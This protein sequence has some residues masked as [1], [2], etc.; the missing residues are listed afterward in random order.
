MSADGSVTFEVRSDNSH[1]DSDL[2]KAEQQIKKKAGGWTSLISSNLTSKL[3][4]AVG[5][6][7]TEVWNL[8]T[9]FEDGMASV[10]T[11][12][13]TASVDMDSLGDQL[14]DLSS[15]YGLEASSLASSAYEAISS[16]SALGENTADLMAIMEKSAKLAK[17]GFTDLDTATQA[18]LKTLNAYGLGVEDADRIQKILIQTQN[19]G[20]VTVDE[21]GHHLAQVTPTAAATGISF[22]EVG[23]ALATMTAIG[24]PAAQATTQLNAAISA[25]LKPNKEM[26]A[27]LEVLA[28]QMIETGQI[29]GENAEQFMYYKQL[30]E[31]L[32]E[33]LANTNTNTKEGK[34]L[35]KEYTEGM[36]NCSKQTAALAG[37][38]SLQILEANGLQ[39][40]LELLNEAFGGSTNQMAL[41][42]GSSEALKA[43]L[44]ITGDQAEVFTQNL[45][46]MSTETDVVNE[47][48][49]KVNNTAS[50]KLNNSLNKI[51]NSA[52]ELYNALAPLLSVLLDLAS[53]IVDKVTGAISKASDWIGTMSSKV[54]SLWSS[55]TSGKGSKGG[56]SGKSF[57]V[58][59]DYIPEDDYPALLHRGEAVLTAAE[60]KVWREGGN[61]RV[62]A[63]GISGGAEIDYQKLARAM[64]GLS[65]MMDG[66]KVGELIE[67]TVSD[68]QARGVESVQRSGFN[69][70]I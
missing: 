68:I 34:E 67:P 50:Q 36:K 11:L 15:K 39:G 5:K 66:K 38:M 1:I 9:A 4:S 17:A 29:T 25:F 23:A 16:N 28:E 30:Q 57:A 64:S 40:T 24:T 63:A 44:S 6:V 41:A 65:V 55:I 7:A 42:L 53:I 60:A 52:V 35:A 19:Y 26:Q 21:L 61:M 58:G 32:G 8:G 13:D 12:V 31:E 48:F 2:D 18:T 54:K 20:I 59:A 3:G 14:L 43:A 22:E 45:E 37:E 33:K 62:G 46:A 47:G 10:S 56:G 70:R 27:G 69:G 49:E 51:K